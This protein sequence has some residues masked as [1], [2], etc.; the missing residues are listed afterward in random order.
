MNI[1]KSIL[2]ISMLLSSISNAEQICVNSAS[3][4][5]LTDPFPPISS[6]DPVDIFDRTAE[7]ATRCF[8][9]QTFRGLD[10]GNEVINSK[11]RLS[12]TSSRDDVRR[13]LRLLL[14]KLQASHTE[15]LVDTDQR[16][17]ALQS[18]FSHQIDGAPFYQIGAMF[19][20]HGHQ[21]FVRSVFEDSPAAH[22]GL[23]RGDE[24][25]SVNDKPLAPVESF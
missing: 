25:V 15:F 23:K 3:D 9:D 24:I 1:L 16:Y 7:I 8:Y 18:V 22:S 2:V 6:S 10:W 21:W 11:A 13:V 4:A 20:R 19:E 17:W 5:C 14:G 12:N